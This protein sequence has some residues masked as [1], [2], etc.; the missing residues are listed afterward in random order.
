MSCVCIIWAWNV[1]LMHT[2]SSVWGW[3]DIYWINIVTRSDLKLIFSRFIYE[4][5]ARLDFIIYFLCPVSSK[6]V[7]IEMNFSC[8]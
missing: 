4:M 6:S 8:K 1:L 2:V 7:D 5:F 3:F